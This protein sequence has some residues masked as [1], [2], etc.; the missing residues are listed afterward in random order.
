MSYLICTV[1][2]LDNVGAFA[3]NGGQGFTL[4]AVPEPSGLV[5][6]GTGAIGLLG[7]TLH[8]RK[9]APPSGPI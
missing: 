7:Y 9:A 6:L 2:T 8:R 1:V 4:S 3:S 5:L